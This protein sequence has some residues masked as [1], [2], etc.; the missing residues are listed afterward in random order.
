MLLCR[1]EDVS[2]LFC[3][4]WEWGCYTAG[5]DHVHLGDIIRKLGV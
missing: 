2:V 4:S 5:D 1:L 3:C